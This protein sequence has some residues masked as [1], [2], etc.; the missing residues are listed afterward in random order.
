M[1]IEIPSQ[2]YY[3]AMMVKH[4]NDAKSALILCS[5]ELCDHLKK[6]V[7]EEIAERIGRIER[8]YRKLYETLSQRKYDPNIVRQVSELVRSVRGGEVIDVREIYS[9]LSAGNFKRI[10]R[11]IL[12]LIFEG[13]SLASNEIIDLVERVVKIG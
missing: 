9:E 2:Y 4:L 6:M 5:E 12:A 3:D 11:K 7:G 10:T 13:K 1:L 8:A